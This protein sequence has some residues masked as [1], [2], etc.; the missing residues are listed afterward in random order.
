MFAAETVPTNNR[1]R[2]L[3]Q[4]R[5][6]AIYGLAVRARCSP[7]T[8]GAAERWGYRP[9]VVVCERIAAALGVP[10]EAIWPAQTLNEGGNV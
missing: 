1:L 2:S 6:W 9:S 4:A 5:G 8:I 3:R 7:T 10:V